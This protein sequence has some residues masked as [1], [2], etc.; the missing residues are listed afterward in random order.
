MLMGISIPIKPH[1][2]G[3]V[4]SLFKKFPHSHGLQKFYFLFLSDNYTC[5]LMTFD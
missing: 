1:F 2:G 3:N 4:D 5:N